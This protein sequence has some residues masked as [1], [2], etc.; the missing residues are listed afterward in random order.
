MPRVPVGVFE[1]ETA[2][3]EVDLPS[4]AGSDHPLEGAIHRRA[5][6]F[7][8]FL[9]HQ[10]DQIVRA[11]V[12]VLAQE[13]TDDQLALGG[14]LATGRA[15]TFEVG[16]LSVHATRPRLGYVRRR[17]RSRTRRWTWRSGS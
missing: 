7:L 15:Q 3:S 16:G 1:A 6:D 8:V 9:T 13:D 17:T 12:S 10:V 11:E 5:T 14:A 2:F 4:D